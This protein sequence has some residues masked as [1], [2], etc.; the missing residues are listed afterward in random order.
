MGVTIDDARLIAATLPRSYEALVR[1]QVRFRVGRMGYAAFYHD[2]TI[3]GFGFPRD[4]RVS[5][6][7][8]PSRRASVP[9]HAAP[10]CGT[11]VA[12]FRERQVA[13]RRVVASTRR[14]SGGVGPDVGEHAATIPAREGPYEP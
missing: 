5:Y 6:V 3:M 10:T 9:S 12:V 8:R 11:V 2:D 7:R 1:D 14:G 4:E 13:R